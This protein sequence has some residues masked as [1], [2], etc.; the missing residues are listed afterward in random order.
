MAD[1]L[2]AMLNVSVVRDQQ[3]ILKDV[4]W[5][6]DR[7]QHWALVGP[8]GSGKTT[9]L[10]IIN[11][12]LWPTRGT[13]SVLGQSFGDVDLRDLRRRLG[14]VSQSLVERVVRYHGGDQALDVVLSGIDASIG[15]YRMPGADD[16]ARAAELLDQLGVQPLAGRPF[17]LLSQ[18]ER[19]RVL[20]ARAWSNRPELLILDEP[21]T[22]LDLVARESLLQGMSQLPAD[23][24]APSTIY[25]TH[26]IEEVLPWFSHALLLSQGEV[27]A[28]GEKREVLSDRPLSRAFGMNIEVV[29]RKARP[30]LTLI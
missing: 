15:L 26:H 24:N 21:A 7:G 13:V 30:W 25:V 19:Q 18:G 27:V 3:R 8:N 10:N 4:N 20:L 29:W 9:L 23:A 5:R 22:G 2:L 6:I 17:G 11:G 16:R 12:N 28:Q 14:W 1:C